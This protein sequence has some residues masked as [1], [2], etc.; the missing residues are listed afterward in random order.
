MSCLSCASRNQ[1]EFTA[2]I[3]IHFPGL[4]NLDKPSVFVFPKL[5]VCLDCGCS[6]FAIPETELARLQEVA[7]QAKHEPRTKV[8][9]LSRPISGLSRG[10][11]M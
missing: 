10:W 2:E 6:R 1:A 9:T 5:S 11:G 3:N 7:R 4:K 8:S